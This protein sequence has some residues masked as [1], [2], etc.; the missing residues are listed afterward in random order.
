LALVKRTDQLLAARVAATEF[1]IAS[2]NPTP[3]SAA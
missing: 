1:V 3:P 2:N